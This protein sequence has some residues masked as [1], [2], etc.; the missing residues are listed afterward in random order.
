MDYDETKFQASAPNILGEFA[1]TKVVPEVDL[2]RIARLAS[3]APVR[4][5]YH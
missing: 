1:R 3:N 2:V 5:L 4:T